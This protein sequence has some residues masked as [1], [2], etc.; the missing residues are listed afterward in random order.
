MINANNKKYKKLTKQ[1][2]VVLT[3]KYCS[4]KYNDHQHPEKNVPWY[5]VPI[6]T[7]HIIW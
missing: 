1:I 5:W 3:L 6:N 7:S 2:L 4:Y